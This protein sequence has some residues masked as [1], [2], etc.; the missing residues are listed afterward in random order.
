MKNVAALI[1]VV[2]FAVELYLASAGSQHKKKKRL[3]GWNLVPGRIVSIEKKVDSSSRKTIYELQIETQDGR[4]IYA[5]EGIFC[6]YEEGE[7]VDLQEK[8]GYHKLLGNDRVGNRGKK[9]SFWGIVPVLVILAISV[10]CSI[11]F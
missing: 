6:I 4:T 11:V 3:S 10:V 2:F 1:I 9:E 8:D 7:A 5:K